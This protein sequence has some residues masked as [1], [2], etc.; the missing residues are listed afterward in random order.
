[1]EG[2]KLQMFWGVAPTDKPRLTTQVAN[3]LPYG[4]NIE[5][6]G[7]QRLLQTGKPDL[8]VAAKEKLRQNGRAAGAAGVTGRRGWTQTQGNW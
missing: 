5:W 3:K 8:L 4:V 2:E 7:E 1:M 6:S